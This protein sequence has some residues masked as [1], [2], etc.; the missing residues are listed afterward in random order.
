MDSHSCVA[1]YTRLAVDEE[2]LYR[3]QRKS[4]LPPVVVHLS[5]AYEYGLAEYL[6]RPRQIGEGD[7]IIIARPEARAV[8]HSVIQSGRDDKIGIGKIGKLMGALNSHTVWTYVP[9]EDK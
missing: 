3:I 6:A 5:D 9:P 4:G 1:S 2:F 8:A 7:F